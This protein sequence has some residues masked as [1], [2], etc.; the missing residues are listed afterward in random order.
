MKSEI[1][2]NEW[3]PAHFFEAMNEVYESTIPEDRGLRDLYVRTAAYQ[4]SALFDNEEFH[5]IMDQHGQFWKDYS[6]GLHANLVKNGGIDQT[7]Y[8]ELVCRKCQNYPRFMVTVQSYQAIRMTGSLVSCPFC[9]NT[10]S[11]FVK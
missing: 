5:E 6:K 4:G 3:T 8:K 11:V 7:K 1:L 9:K 10:V 2:L